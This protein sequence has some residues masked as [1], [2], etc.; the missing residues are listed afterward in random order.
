MSKQSTRASV[1]H[2]I[3]GNPLEDLPKSE[4]AT[5]LQVASHVLVLKQRKNASNLDVIPQ[6]S[7]SIIELWKHAGIFFQAIKNV[8]IKVH[9]Y[10]D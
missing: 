10:R 6:V 2:S 5:R 8:K 3:F 9:L 7:K 4:L 1:S